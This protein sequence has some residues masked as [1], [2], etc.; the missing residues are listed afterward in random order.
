MAP[1]EPQKLP[2]LGQIGF[3]NSLPVTLPIERQLVDIGA[4]QILDTPAGLNAKYAEGSL[5]LGAMSTFFYLKSRSMTLI[6]R[7]SISGDGAVGSVLYFGK[8][9]PNKNKP[10]RI[11]VPFASATSVCLV[12]VLFMEQFGVMPQTVAMEKPNL[13]G[14]VDGALV[15]GD[16]ALSVDADWSSRY[17]RQDLGQWWKSIFDLPMVFGLWAARTSFSERHPAEFSYISDGLVRALN[18]GLG[19]AFKDVVDEAHKRTGHGNVRLEHYY[20]HELDFTF[21]DRHRT[22]LEKYESLC[23]QYGLLNQKAIV[24]AQ[25][26]SV[27]S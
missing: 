26:I 9:K 5:D 12:Q 27:R 23:I 18:V 20:R 11:A 8:N 17:A 14:E 1:S 10:F 15:I 25:G 19:D 3:I 24:S 7:L 6:P 21:T 2:R 13:E 22:A 4:E 16:Y